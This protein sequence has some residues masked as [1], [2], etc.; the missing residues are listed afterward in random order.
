[1]KSL[2]SKSLEIFKRP[3]TTDVPEPIQESSLE[4]EKQK[5]PAK[6]QMRQRNVR[7]RDFTKRE[8]RIKSS[9]SSYADTLPAY[10]VKHSHVFD[11]YGNP[12]SKNKNLRRQTAL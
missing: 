12:N 6:S 2:A 7:L 10:A 1:M 11:L 3:A 8:R 4:I 5:R 9:H